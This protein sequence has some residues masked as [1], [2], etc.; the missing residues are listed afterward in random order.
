MKIVDTKAGI[1]HLGTSEDEFTLG[2]AQISFQN[3][4]AENQAWTQNEQ[5]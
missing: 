4:E 5:E 3:C 1:V 2:T